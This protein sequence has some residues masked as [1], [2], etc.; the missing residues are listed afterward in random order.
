M[1]SKICGCCG[2]EVKSPYY[3][4]H[5]AVCEKCIETEVSRSLRDKA[6]KRKD[7]LLEL[8]DQDVM[9]DETLDYLLGLPNKDFY[10]F[11]DRR[12]RDPFVW[13]AG[14][15]ITNPFFKKSKVFANR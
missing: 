3:V 7:E 13:D 1:K 4:N 10:S 12:E 15:H 11:V 8:F 9:E 6:A 14:S 2:T 5:M